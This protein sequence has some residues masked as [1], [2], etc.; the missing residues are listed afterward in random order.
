MEGLISDQNRSIGTL[1]ITTLLKT[2]NESSIERLLKQITSFMAD[3]QV[4]V[5][6][7]FIFLST[8]DAFVLNIFAQDEFKILVVEAIRSLCIKFP[9][10]HRV[11]MSFLSTI[12][13]E[14]GSFEYKKSIVESIIFLIKDI[15]E[16]KESGLSYLS[17]FIEDCEFTYLSSQIL[18]L[19]GEQ[20]PSTD[21]PSKYIRYIYNRVILE[22]AT[23]RA[24]AVCSL[25][26]FGHKCPSL[27]PRI[28]TLLRRCMYDNDDE[29]RDRA[30][31]SVTS[32]SD[33]ARGSLAEEDRY[34]SL[35]TLQASLQDYLLK[36]QNSGFDFGAVSDP[37]EFGMQIAKATHS[38]D[39]SQPR[40]DSRSRKDSEES[41]RSVTQIVQ[42]SQLGPIFKVRFFFTDFIVCNIDHFFIHQSCK[43]VELTEA[44][45]EY[46]VNSQKYNTL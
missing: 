26:K 1:A 34:C 28:I 44:E 39:C 45:T 8:Q 23:I 12:L 46:K 4:F 21:D 33:F 17:E 36:P 40:P 3:I 20:G 6:F 37:A 19:L 38:E 24:S 5:C 13:R 25:S 14:E 43:A 32:L 35:A 22:N 16:A 15:P 29:V 41:Q 31:F 2:G 9:K 7:A 42:F 30:T 10:K 27:A 18:Y 11:L